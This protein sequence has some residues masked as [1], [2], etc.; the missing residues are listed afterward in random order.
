MVVVIMIET[1]E[2]VANAEKIAAVP[3]IDVIFAASTDLGNFS[4]HKQGEPQYEAL[5]TRIKDATLARGLKLGGPLAW[6]DRPGFSFFQAPGETALI[7]AGAQAI[8]KSAP[9]PATR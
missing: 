5:V 2:G 7:Q 8:L 1:P 3:G 6:K 9:A 4:G